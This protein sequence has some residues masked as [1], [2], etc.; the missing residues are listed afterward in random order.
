MKH[1]VI[2]LEMNCTN[3]QYYKNAKCRMEIIQIGAILLDEDYKEIGSFSTLVKPQYNNCIEQK[4]VEL[5][6]ITWEMVQNAPF[7]EEAIHSFF[8]WIETIC[9]EVEIVSW[10]ENDWIQ[11]SQEAYAKQYIFSDFEDKCLD[12]WN[13]FQEE[14]GHTLFLDERCSLMKA[15]QKANLSFQGQQHNAL[16]DAKNTANLLAIVRDSKKCRQ[17]FGQVMD[18]HETTSC[19]LGDLFDFS[20][21]VFD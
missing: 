4:Y 6:G 3:K 5:T 16:Y 12:N 18:Y 21:F 17:T 8:S 9:D 19:T 1:V 11:I 20:N 14:Y 10:S 7:F 2:D 15:V 13:D